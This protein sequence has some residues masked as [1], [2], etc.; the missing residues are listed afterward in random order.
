MCYIWISEQIAIISLHSNNWFVFITERLCVYSAVRTGS[1]SEIAFRPWRVNGRLATKQLVV[2]SFAEM[3]QVTCWIAFYVTA[4]ANCFVFCTRQ[5]CGKF[6]TC[7][8]HQT[9]VK[10][11]QTS[12][13]L[14]AY[15][16]W[17]Q[18]NLRRHKPRAFQ[19]HF[20]KSVWLVWEWAVTFVFILF[21]L[22]VN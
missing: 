8:R 9:S 3:T 12:A 17:L 10:T 11:E 14:K 2:L 19:W 13:L 6:Y 22:K 21:L 20:K 18:R 7:W 15:Y 4:F 5:S 1:L 16:L